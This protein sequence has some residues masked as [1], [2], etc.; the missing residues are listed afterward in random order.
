MA[1]SG[2][3]AYSVTVQTVVED[4]LQNIGVLGAGDALESAD[5]AFVLRKLNLLIKQWVGQADF[6]PGLK[7]WTRRRA[8]LFLQSGQSEYSLGPSGDHAAESSY[9]TTTLASAAAQSAGTVT[10]TSASGIA[11]AD[12]IGIRM[13][14]GPIHWTTV[15]GAPSG[16]VVT[17]TVAMAGAAA[18]GSRVFAYTAKMR[19]PFEIVSAVRR[20]TAGL[21][22]TIDPNMGV[23][24][25]EAIGDK[26]ATATPSRLYLES[27][28]TS[29]T[30]YIDCEPADTTQVLRLVYLSYIEDMGALSE[31]VDLPAEW[32]RPLS[33][34][35]S[36][37]IAPAYTRPVTQEMK[38]MRDES[39]AIARNAF[40][41]KSVACFESGP[42]DY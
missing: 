42:D 27:R 29:A 31:D 15:S 9:V 40:P 14:G 32:L 21:D 16:A 11:A 17:L 8:Y 28:R 34:Q 12:Y 24:E 18:A 25:Y 26:G 30:A 23:D 41:A 22:T 20:D 6:A 1:T 35:L 37:D 10:L 36:L 3:T 4:A 2:T 39:L 38:L 19:K 5:A 13:D 7:L 33:A